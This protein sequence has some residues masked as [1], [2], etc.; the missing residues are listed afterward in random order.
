M[1]NNI[2][3]KLLAPLS[4]LA[5]IFL[6][7][8]VSLIYMNYKKTDI[9]NNLNNEII[10]ATKLSKL[11]HATQIERGLSVGYL[12]SKGNLFKKELILQREKTN[13]KINEL[14]YFSQ[15]E[16]TKSINLQVAKFLNNLSK[17]L[18]NIQRIREK[19]LNKS[20]SNA[21]TI[22]YYSSCNADI[23]NTIIEVS[24]ISPIVI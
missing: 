19:I 13:D 14:K 6:V 24:K 16:N 15:D 12:S 7:L 23:L 17:K 5:T 20:L 11:M 1:T 4:I 2:K 10:L 9:L 3:V 8:T 22:N 18:V 21:D